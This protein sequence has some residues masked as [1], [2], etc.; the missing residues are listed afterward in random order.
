MQLI[1][2]AVVSVKSMYNIISVRSSAEV[3]VKK[4]QYSQLEVET[5]LRVAVA[6]VFGSSLFSSATKILEN[7][8]NAGE[9]V[10]NLCL[11]TSNVGSL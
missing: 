2:D 3:P 5:K 8:N 7:A 10:S 9:Y 11:L 1:W 6:F 4:P